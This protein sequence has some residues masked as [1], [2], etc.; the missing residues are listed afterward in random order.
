M[1]SLADELM[2]ERIQEAGLEELLILRYRDDYRIFVNNPADGETVLKWLTEV[3]P[4]WA[5]G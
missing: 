2:S 1:L 3:D 5:S 4:D